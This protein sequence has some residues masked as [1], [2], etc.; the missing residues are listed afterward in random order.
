MQT[1]YDLLIVFTFS[2]LNNAL[3]DRQD[4][5]SSKIQ[6]DIAKA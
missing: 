2:A 4:N 6:A 5:D 1:V 3:R